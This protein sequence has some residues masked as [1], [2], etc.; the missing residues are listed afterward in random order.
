MTKSFREIALKQA[1]LLEKKNRAYGGSFNKTSEHLKLLFPDGIV[2]D[3][4]Q[5]VMFIIR[6][7]DK[8]SRIANSS[9]LPPEEGCLDAYFDINGY[10]FLAI[11]KMLDEKTLE[12]ETVKDSNLE[13]MEIVNEENNI[14]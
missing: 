9:L 4:Y 7:L 2:D 13:E 1:E 11:K 10:S 3:Q 12:E 8:L 5:H 6:V 14:A